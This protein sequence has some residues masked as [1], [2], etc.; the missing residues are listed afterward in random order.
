MDRKN[1]FLCIFDG[2]MLQPLLFQ[3]L[4]SVYFSKVC[5]LFFNILQFNTNYDSIIV[6]LLSLKIDPLQDCAL[7]KSIHYNDEKSF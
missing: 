4:I 3:F 6:C 1:Y 7:N 5:A 2:L